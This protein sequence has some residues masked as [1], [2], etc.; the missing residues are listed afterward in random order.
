ML[1]SLVAQVAALAALVYLPSEAWASGVGQLAFFLKGTRSA[2]GAFTQTTVDRKGKAASQ[3]MS[4]TFRFERPGKFFWS[5][6]KP[7][8]Q[9]IVSN[10]KKVYVWD[11]DLRQVTVRSLAGAMPASPAAILFG[12][13]DF[14]RDFDVKEGRAESGLEWIEAVPK[15]RDSSFTRILIGFQNGLPG[16][17]V[18]RDNF[19]QTT[20]LRLSG[21]EKNPAIPAGAFEFRIPKGAEVLQQ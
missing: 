7:Y 14:R 13:N 11:P 8:R 20:T 18:L 6:E 16:E 19:G 3:A 21:V 9:E 5:Y 2:S 1:K 12:N 10:G 15:V 17:M 4:G